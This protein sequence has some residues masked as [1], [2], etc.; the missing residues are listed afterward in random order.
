M[1]DRIPKAPPIILPITNDEKSRP[2]FSVMIPTYNCIQYLRYAM[3]GVLSQDPGEE[4]MQIEVIDDCSTDGDVGALVREIGKG[5]VAIYQQ[6]ENVGSLRNFETCINRARGFYVHILH[7]DDFVKNGFYKEIEDLFNR[8]P[9]IGSAMTNFNW[10]DENNV[11]RG[12]NRDIIP[13]IGIIDN[14]LERIASKQLVQPPAVVVKRSTYEAVGSFFAVH[15]G[16]DWE[17]WIRIASRFEMAY[18]PKSLAVYRS[19]HVSNISTNSILAGKNFKDLSTVIAIASNYLPAST[20]KEIRR[21]AKKDF[22][23]SFARAS[24]QLLAKEK[25]KR[26]ALKLASG[27]L[28]FSINLRSVYWA[29]RF[30]R[31]YFKNLLSKRREK[32][33]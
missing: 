30:Y 21:R 24:Y 12:V 32:N 8:F 20:R 3:E 13:Y 7:G 18:S 31:L 28:K 22:S 29:S 23:I 19:G 16:E 27:A 2:L 14:W 11:Q 15:Y 1:T 9:A 33:N 25:D 17:M 4:K 10:V 26:L 5:R 6:P